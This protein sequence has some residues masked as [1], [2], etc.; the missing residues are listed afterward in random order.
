M[1]ISDM[2]MNEGI[3]PEAKEWKPER[4]LDGDVLHTRLDPYWTPFGRGPRMCQG[5]E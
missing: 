4:W 5:P 1:T 2:M 3:Y